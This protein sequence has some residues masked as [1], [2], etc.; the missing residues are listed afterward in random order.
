MVV[1]A[2]D[3]QK[4][5]GKSAVKFTFTDP[6]ATHY[7]K[8]GA[9]TMVARP[10]AVKGDFFLVHTGFTDDEK[11]ATYIDHQMLLHIPTI[12]SCK[13]VHAMTKTRGA[14]EWMVEDTE[15]WYPPRKTERAKKKR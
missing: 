12:K 4:F 14:F 6:V 8:K 3:L 10:L 11:S 13:L 7:N 15:T 2:K 9:K 5:I 1:T